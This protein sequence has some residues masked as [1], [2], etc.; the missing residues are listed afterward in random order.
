MFL[1][2]HHV[3][4]SDSSE[5]WFFLPRFVHCLF[6]RNLFFNLDFQVYQCALLLKPFHCFFLSFLFLCVCFLGLYMEQHMEVSG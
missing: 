4:V 5:S 2:F 1:P 6:S 3:L